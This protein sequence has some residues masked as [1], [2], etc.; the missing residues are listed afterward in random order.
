MPSGGCG[1]LWAGSLSRWLL[2]F[3]QATV[4][5]HSGRPPGPVQLLRTL[6]LVLC[7]LFLGDRAQ[8]AWSL[9]AIVLP[10]LGTLIKGALTHLTLFPCR[11]VNSKSAGQVLVQTCRVHLNAGIA[12]S[13]CSGN[14]VDSA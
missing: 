2:S 5:S 3:L 10:S 4:H 14:A 7:P 11:L 1:T 12:C 6:L 9:S 8:C 13:G